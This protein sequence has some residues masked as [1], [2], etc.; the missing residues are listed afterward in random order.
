MTAIIDPRARVVSNLGVVEN[1]GVAR[2]KVLGR[3]L[4]R[5]TGDLQIASSIAPVRGTRVELAYLWRGGLTR[6][7]FRLYVLSSATNPYGRSTTV[8][9]GCR[10]ALLEQRRPAAPFRADEHPPAWYSALSS[11]QRLQATPPITA[12]GL[13]EWCA[14]G[15]GVPIAPGSAVLRGNLMRAEEQASDGFAALLQGVLQSH[16]CAATLNAAEQLVIRRVRL[17]PG[18]GPIFDRRTLIEI[19]PVGGNDGGAQRLTV[20]YNAAIAP[21]GTGAPPPA[22]VIPGA[23]VLATAVGTPRLLP[24]GAPI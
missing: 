4:L 21:P 13:V 24:D 20:R 12:Q 7:P 11:E 18:A 2:D 5:H 9:V 16:C 14:A 3:W 10:I 22:G 15:L 17:Q 6:F 1:G 23:G 8:K 19:S